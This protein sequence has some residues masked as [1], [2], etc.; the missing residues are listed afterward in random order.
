MASPLIV[1][2]EASTGHSPHLQERRAHALFAS[3]HAESE[4]RPTLAGLHAAW[5]GFNTTYFDARLVEPHIALGRTAPRSLGHCEPTTGYGGRLQIAI[6]EG[7]V[8]RPNRDWVRKSWPA[9]GLRRFVVDL[10]LR[11]TVRQ[12][13]LEALGEEEAGYRGYGPLFTKEAN[14]IG[15]QLGLPQVVAR[16]R[17]GHEDEGPP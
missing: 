4:Y 9:E 8:I 5:R 17:P 12:H 1:T 2:N 7:L 14:R 16:R 6:N 13:V 11:F 15:L 3:E 10:L